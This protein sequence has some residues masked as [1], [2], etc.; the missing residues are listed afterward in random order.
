MT[1]VRFIGDVHGLVHELSELLQN[2]SDVVSE[3]FQVGDMGVGFG[4]SEYWRDRLNGMLEAKNARWI[5]GNHDNPSVCKEMT[6]WIPDGTVKNDMMFIGGA[7]SIDRAHRT[8]GV[9]WWPNEELSMQELYDMIDLYE[10]VRPKIMVTHDA[11]T[12]A[13][14]QMFFTENRPIAKFPQT[15]TRTAEALETMFQIHQP[16]LHVFGHWHY[17]VDKTINGTRFIC[18]NEM[19][20]IDVDVATCEVVWPSY[21]NVRK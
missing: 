1:K 17:D 13:A 14:T 11:P 4:E 3:V 21:L 10:V 12:S 5:R 20:H 6:T 8:E 19:S 15:N 9:N 16:K 18:L 7:W 2:T